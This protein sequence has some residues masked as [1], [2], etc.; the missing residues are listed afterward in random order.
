MNNVCKLPYTCYIEYMELNTQTKEENSMSVKITLSNPAGS[1]SITTNRSLEDAI[2]WFGTTLVPHGTH[3]SYLTVSQ[4]DEYA[5]LVR[6]IP[7]SVHTLEFE[8]QA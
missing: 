3:Y 7:N 1:K 4:T 2:Q 8:L 6:N 5:M